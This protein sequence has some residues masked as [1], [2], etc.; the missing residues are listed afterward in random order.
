MRPSKLPLPARVPASLAAALLAAL[1]ACG[2]AQPGGPSAAPKASFEAMKVY[3]N[4]GQALS[5]EAPRRDCPPR[6]PDRELSD[7]CALAGFRMVQCGCDALCTGNVSR[8]A[9]QYYDAEGHAKICEPA[10]PD[11]DAPPAS[12]AFQ[13]GCTER[14]YRLEMC[15][16]EWLCSGS[17]SK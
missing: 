7:R 13:D 14:G 5:C 6:A 10:K 15:G 3:D 17:F 8:A 9:S 16:C 1:V 2:G 12:A 4:S 11:C